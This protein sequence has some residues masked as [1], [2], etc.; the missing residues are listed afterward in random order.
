[1]VLGEQPLLR[2]FLSYRHLSTKCFYDEAALNG[3]RNLALR[4][5]HTAS[6]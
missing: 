5:Y 6:V 2:Q 4:G 1:M 3:W